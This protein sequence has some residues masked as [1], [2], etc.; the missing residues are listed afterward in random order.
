M[1]YYPS[2][3]IRRSSP[4]LTLA[5]PLSRSTPGIGGSSAP[6]RQCRI[7]RLCSAPAQVWLCLRGASPRRARCN[8][9][10]VPGPVMMCGTLANAIV[11]AWPGNVP[12]RKERRVSL[13]QSSLVTEQVKTGGDPVNDVGGRIKTADEVRLA[14]ACRGPRTWPGTRAVTRRL[15][16]QFYGFKIS[17][18]SAAKP[19]NKRNLTLLYD[20]S[21]LKLE[22]AQ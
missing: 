7:A 19:Q 22:H 10:L 3:N 13:K 17:S 12:G 4:P 2:L 1:S 6:G 9:S 18:L 16:R 15:E 8:Q 5:V 14:E 11:E 21:A 20:R